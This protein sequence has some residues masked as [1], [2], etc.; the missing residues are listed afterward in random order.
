MCHL[1]HAYQVWN[2][3]DLQSQRKLCSRQRN[4]A[5]AANATTADE[6]NPYMLPFQATQKLGKYFCHLWWWFQ[7]QI[8]WHYNQVQ[9]FLFTLLTLTL[10]ESHY[11][12]NSPVHL[13]SLTRF[14]IAGWQTS[15]IHLDVPKIYRLIQKWWWRL[16]YDS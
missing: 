6:S 14:F 5:A 15:N 11:H 9:I 10:L 12:E 3:L 7:W 2:D 13:C 4:P 1:T 16:F 8:I